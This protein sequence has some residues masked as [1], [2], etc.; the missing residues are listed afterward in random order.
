MKNNLKQATVKA[1]HL[2]EM[3]L[4]FGFVFNPWTKFPYTFAIIII[5]LILLYR[6]SNRPLLTLGFKSGIPLWRMVIWSLPVF[7]ALELVMDFMVQPVVT[8]LAHDPADYTAFDA[9]AG[10]TPKYLKYLAYMWISA[11]IGE[12][13]LFRGYFFDKLELLFGQIKH[14]GMIIVFATALLFS[15][16]H[17]YQGVAGLVVT[18][19]FGLAFGLVYLQTG[20]VLWINIIVHGLVDTLFLTLAYLDYLNY[21]TLANDLLI[22]Y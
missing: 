11:A 6:V 20:K 16:P 15:L 3:I 13:L 9:L 21:Y 12:E 18:F 7:L 1:Q 4:V 10:N 14:R 5:G 22:G 17:L 8:K 19:I 2:I